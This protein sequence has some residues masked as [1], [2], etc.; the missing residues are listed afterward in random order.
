MSD[1][2]RTKQDIGGRSVVITS[3]FDDSR[4]NWHAGAPRYAHLSSLL[5]PAPVSC[6]TRNTAIQHMANL[7]AAHF[8]SDKASQ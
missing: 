4:Q 6:A 2:E 1:F 8:N 3:W 7:L 5:P